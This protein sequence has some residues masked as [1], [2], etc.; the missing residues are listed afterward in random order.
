MSQHGHPIGARAEFL[1]GGSPFQKKRATHTTAL[2]ERPSK[3]LNLGVW[4]DI[5]YFASAHCLPR[6]SLHLRL[7]L[8]LFKQRLLDPPDVTALTKKRPRDF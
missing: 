4:R 5:S 1:L 6:G 7:S 8:P 3:G 2:D